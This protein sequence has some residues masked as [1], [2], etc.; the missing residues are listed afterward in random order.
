MCGWNTDS[1][2][3]ISLNWQIGSPED[4]PGKHEGV[5]PGSSNPGR[6]AAAGPRRSCDPESQV[7]S[8][9]ESTG[10]HLGKDGLF[11]GKPMFPGSVEFLLLGRWI[12]RY[13]ILIARRITCTEFLQEDV[14]KI[15]Q[16]R[17]TASPNRFLVV[18]FYKSNTEDSRIPQSARCAG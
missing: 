12:N 2:N 11:F 16:Q 17:S 4:G 15:R 7:Y 10:V 18:R 1:C 8:H 5:A 9:L 13:V 6:A 14:R 3:F